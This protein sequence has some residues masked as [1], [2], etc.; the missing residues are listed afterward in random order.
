[1]RTTMM[2]ATVP[3]TAITAAMTVLDPATLSAVRNTSII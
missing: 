3:K 2:I 1:M